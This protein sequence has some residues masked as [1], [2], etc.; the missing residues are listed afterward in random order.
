MRHKLQT[1]ASEGSVL[2]AEGLN[3]RLSTFGGQASSIAQAAL[4]C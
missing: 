3:K 1:C 2:L 4:G